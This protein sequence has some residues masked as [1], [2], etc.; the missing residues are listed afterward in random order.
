MSE[1]DSEKLTFT[2]FGIWFLIIQI[3]MLII[4]IPN[5]WIEKVVIEEATM[6]EEDFGYQTSSYILEK[7]FSWYE[8]AFVDSG[9][10]DKVYSFFMLTEDERQRST[11]LEELGKNTWYPWIEERGRTLRLTLI[12]IF[13][14]LSQLFIWIPFFI[15]IMITAAWDGYMSWKLKYLSFAYS[16]P[17]FHRFS[18]KAINIITLSII[19]IMF[20]PVAIKPIILP[21]VIL[22]TT[23]AIAIAL[24][25]NLPKKI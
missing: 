17:W 22:V 3:L 19:L 15:L 20:I 16:S 4:L 1:Q 14:R 21:L 2:W 24:I 13:D 25:S 12:L 11:G 7:G 5:S 18:M 10:N 23:P 6:L 9:I 8:F